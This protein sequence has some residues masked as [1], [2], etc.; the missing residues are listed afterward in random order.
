MQALYETI[1][2]D[3]RVLEYAF[4][5]EV[6]ARESRAGLGSAVVREQGSTQVRR[7]DKMQQKVRNRALEEDTRR[8]KQG[9]HRIV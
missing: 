3:E 1:L 8:L 9:A 4:K 5:Y 7:N 2:E 6:L